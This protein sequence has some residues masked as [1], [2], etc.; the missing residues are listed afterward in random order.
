MSARLKTGPK[1]KPL[2]DRFWKNI[3]V[4]LLTGC[5]NWTASLGTGGY[6]QIEIGTKT[7]GQTKRIGGH[8]LGWQLYNGEIPAGLHVL[9]K[10]D[11]RR[12]C[13]PDHLFLGTHR[14]NMVDAAA[15]GRIGRRVTN[16]DAC[17][18]G[19]PY[20]PNNFADYGYGK[21]CMECQRQRTK[22]HYW[23]KRRT[24]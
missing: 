14:D 2:M 22:K 16:T 1:P 10:C 3:D 24:A 4:D 7:G 20:F 17:S 11:N 13:N 9:H 19:H 15:K 6:G 18:K 8:R 12:C 5:W 23:S 21:V